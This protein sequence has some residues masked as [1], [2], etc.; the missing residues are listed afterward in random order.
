MAKEH[1]QFQSSTKKNLAESLIRG[2]DGIYYLPFSTGTNRDLRQELTDYALYKATGIQ[3]SKAQQKNIGERV[4]GLYK[5][6]VNSI[7]KEPRTDEE[8]LEAIENHE[9][10]PLG[11][12]YLIPTGRDYTRVD[13]NGN[14]LV[15]SINSN[16]ENYMDCGNI[17]INGQ[18]G[19]TIRKPQPYMIIN[20]CADNGFYLVELYKTQIDK[21]TGN[22]V[23]VAREYNFL[24][25]NGKMVNSKHNFKKCTFDEKHVESFQRNFYSR[26]GK[27]A[28]SDWD[29]YP[30]AYVLCTQREPEFFE[31]EIDLIR[32]NRKRTNDGLEPIV[33]NEEPY[34]VGLYTRQQILDEEITK[35]GKMFD[36]KQ[37]DEKIYHEA[38]DIINE[39][40]ANIDS[41]S[42]E[43][44]ELDKH[45]AKNLE[46][47]QNIYFPKVEEESLDNSSS[48]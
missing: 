10:G 24:D 3:P 1:I 16:L 32:E 14:I 15:A 29:L 2:S 6:G 48:L 31:S 25:P 43:E 9:I 13:Q 33:D 42:L 20:K 30:T 8:F 37:I 36:E 45:I 17:L 26:N 46:Y 35:L 11:D 44:T 7:T 27:Y 39:E 4:W 12:S 38:L 23:V 40:Y 41:F 18:T 19:E 34:L 5:R 21:A 22:K 28:L 47:Y